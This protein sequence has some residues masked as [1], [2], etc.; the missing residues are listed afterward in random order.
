MSNVATKFSN[1]IKQNLHSVFS[2]QIKTPDVQI[3]VL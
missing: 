1:K 3:D 2:Y